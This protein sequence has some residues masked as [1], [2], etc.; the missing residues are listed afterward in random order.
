MPPRAGP[1][2]PPPTQRSPLPDAAVS[3]ASDTLPAEGAA[4]SR[5][6]DG[7]EPLPRGSVV[8][9]YVVLAQ[10]GSGGMGVV[11]TAHDP[12]LDRKVALKLLRFGASPADGLRL[13]REARALARLAHPNIVAVHDVGALGPGEAGGELFIA[14]ELIAGVTARAWLHQRER[15]TR[16]ILAVY[17]AA[18]RG[19]AA[20]HQA[21]LVHR[22]FKPDNMMIGDD[23]RARVMDFGLARSDSGSVD[24]SSTSQPT[25]PDLR[26]TR[27]GSLL[28]TPLYMAPEQWEGHTVD[29]RSDQFAFCVALW[30][31]LYDTRPFAGA[32]MPALMSAVTRGTI[33]R[34]RASRRR[35]PRWIE[36]VL[37]R[38]LA[39][40]PERRYP[41]M[42]ALLLAL[43]RGLTRQ[44]RR[45][46]LLLGLAGGLAAAGVFGAR[47][48]RESACVAEGAAIAEL[49]NADTRTALRAALL[50]TGVPYAEESFTKAAPYL[51]RWTADWSATRSQV[52]REATI[53]GTRSDASYQAASACLDDAREGVAAL[54]EVFTADPAAHV[55]RLVPAVA[56]LAQLGPCS[57]RGALERRPAPPDDPALRESAHALRRQLLRARGLLA[58][59]AC[60][61]ADEVDALLASAEALALPPLRV[62]AWAL[63]AA[64]AE[65]RGEPTRAEEALRRVYALAEASGADEAAAA[66]AA[67][68][69][70]VIG[71]DR[72][73]AAE[74]LQWSLPAEVILER[75]GA[76]DGLPGVELL[77]SRA[78]VL[79][80]RG[81]LDAAFADM[82]RAL[83]IREALLGPEHPLVATTLNG[84]GS[85]HRR[86]NQ[87]DEALAVQTR[88]LAIRRA[89]L[90]A[91]HP[92][93]AVAANDLGLLEQSRGHH[94][95]AKTYFE[96]AL[97]IAEQVGGPED[98]EVA[99][100]L[101]NLGRLQHLRGDY[102]EARRL[103][104]RALAIREARLGPNHLDV[105]ATQ[106][107]LGLLLLLQGDRLG[108]RQLL[109]RVLAIRERQ[110]DDSHP[111]LISILN[112]L[113]TVHYRT[114]DEAQALTL[115]ERALAS[116][117][118]RLPAGHRDIASSLR[119]LAL[120]RDAR[121]EHDAALD[122]ASEAASLGEQALGR[123]HPDLAPFLNTLGMLQRRRDPVLAEATLTRA[124][125]LSVR[126]RGRRHAAAA[127]SLLR[128]GE[129]YLDRRMDNEAQAS[130]DEALAIREGLGRDTPEV[131][132]VLVVLAELALARGRPGDAAPL[133]ER[134]LVIR[135]KDGIPGRQ[136]AAVRFALARALDAA[137]PSERARSRELAQQAAAAW[138]ADGAASAAELA[139]VSAWAKL[140]P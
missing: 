37:V 115:H 44:R 40:Q 100:I 39:R 49:W 106:H 19:L 78:I 48:R 99:L 89:A 129:V 135:S 45:P 31:A 122:L 23:G 140:H 32:T 77:Q 5:R 51:E 98:L 12:E 86:R 79:R 11:Y 59:G 38:G 118:R 7:D 14:M 88:A 68:L 30:E 76:T 18:G 126:G 13:L 87:L 58:A 61:S 138:Q 124:L 6:I 139:A 128:L 62:D 120:V 116:Q 104:G 46:L 110:L 90:G 125:A 3:V 69:I 42:D 111:E 24:V 22:D 9:R 91:G 29:A 103:L 41:S 119:N 83:T 97:A 47:A 33:E 95:A 80:S 71:R 21:G 26:L 101:N 82:T 131:A 25:A 15:T 56:E 57:E 130:L 109:T 10:L 52:C 73:R 70:S 67:Q 96:E 27:E 133:L 105:A 64:M 132:E 113:G 60:A 75:I 35:V 66:A 72:G 36:G 107:N 123:E 84:L 55:D 81:D 112:D 50:A 92:D 43:E 134:A 127:T 117:R 121:G 136:L 20:A 65:C 63:V 8:G 108:A 34:P 54:L 93:I 114:G 2:T 28:G 53:A 16:E 94:D 4:D 17:T 102:V 137:G 85:I 1:T 74:A